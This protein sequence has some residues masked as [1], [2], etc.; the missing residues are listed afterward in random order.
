MEIENLLKKAQS[1]GWP[2]RNI[3]EIIIRMG[4]VFGD[5]LPLGQ[6]R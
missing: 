3:E 2:K 4:K 5:V 1:L 6:K